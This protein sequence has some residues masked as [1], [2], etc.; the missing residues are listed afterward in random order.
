MALNKE[1]N[2][3]IPAKRRIYV[4]MN[5]VGVDLGVSRCCGAVMR[6]W[7]IATVPLDN[8]GERTLPSYVSYDEKYVKCGKVVVNRL[9]YHSKSTI[10]D[11]KKIIGKNI[12]DIEID[13]SWPFKIKSINGKV[14]LEIH[15]F[16]GKGCFTSEEVT[17]DLLK[18]IKQ[19][20]QE[21][22]GKK[23]S[24]VIITVPLAFTVKQ[25][26]GIMEAA[27]LA[28]WNEIAFLP[29]P[30]AAAFA[31]FIDRPI[32]RN[33]NVLL[34]DFGGG[35]LDVCIFKVENKQIQLLSNIDDSTT[36]GKNFDI[37]LFNYFKNALYTK[38]NIPLIQ[39]KR[40]LLIAKCQEIK[41]TLS[42]QESAT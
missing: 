41:E 28:G 39:N 29:E 13:P 8:T 24:K 5:C 7:E 25:K 1:E 14:F 27:K 6:K 4:D 2:F 36:A 3:I 23:L 22:Q 20:S 11:S 12:E 34:V 21:F 38:Y 18:Y 33:S 17:S 42:V 9:K 32:S 26:A 16:D 40:Y 35:T 37:I 10:Y 15:K 31:Y 19:K 30:V